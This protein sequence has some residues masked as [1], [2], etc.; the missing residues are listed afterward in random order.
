MMNWKLLAKRKTTSSTTLHLVDGIQLALLLAWE[1][2]E[3][4]LQS[5]FFWIEAV[6]GSM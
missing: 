2:I 5:V 4:C 1:P 3:V 6:Q